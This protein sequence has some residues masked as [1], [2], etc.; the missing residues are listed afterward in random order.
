[1]ALKKGNAVH[2]AL[3]WIVKERMA[4][5]E[6]GIEDA[7]RMARDEMASVRNMHAN[8]AY[9]QAESSLEKIMGRYAEWEAESP[10]SVVDTEVEFKT[11]IDG[12]MYKGKIDRV[13]RNPDG[14]YEIVDFK[15]GAGVIKSDVVELNPQ[16]NI[17]AQ[18]ALEEYGSMPAKASM[19]YL[20]KTKRTKREYAVTD[21][22][23]AAGITAVKECAKDIVDEK[24]DA[25]PEYDTYH[26]CPYKSIC[27]D[28]AVR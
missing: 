4:G 25:T 2:G 5:H 19:V 21:E 8:E 27:P 7:K 26:G 9:E 16:L 22:S 28:A 10:N 6:G 1:M 17:Y 15:T 3:D 13:E 14:R 18:A 12:I 24:F 23:L 11:Y 20:E